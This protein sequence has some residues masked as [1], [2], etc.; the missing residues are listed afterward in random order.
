VHDPDDCP[1]FEGSIDFTFENDKHLTMEKIKLLIIG[2]VNYF[3]KIY[4]EK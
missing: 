3:K 2:E 4:N 1:L